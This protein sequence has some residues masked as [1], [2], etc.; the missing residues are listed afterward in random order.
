MI[1]RLSRGMVKKQQ[2]TLP[3]VI[4]LSVDA[5]T[6]KCKKCE[7]GP[8]YNNA[9]H[10]TC[11]E[12]DVYKNLKKNGRK[13]ITMHYVADLAKKFGGM[14]RA[15]IHEA[16]DIKRHVMCPWS[17]IFGKATSR[18]YINNKGQAIKTAW[19]VRCKER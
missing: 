12:S 9:Y 2:M 14:R 6:L 3:G 15:H 19:N 13:I 7:R 11:K 8:K 10:L 18:S 4:E 16:L 17:I 5:G 1:G